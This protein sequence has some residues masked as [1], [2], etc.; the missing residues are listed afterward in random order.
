MNDFEAGFGIPQNAKEHEKE[1]KEETRKGINRLKDA[2]LGKADHEDKHA[3]E[4]EKAKK[5]NVMKLEFEGLAVKGGEEEF[6]GRLSNIKTWDMWKSKYGF[7]AS[8]IMSLKEGHNEFDQVTGGICRLADSGRLCIEL[9][10]NSGLHE[11]TSDKAV[12]HE[13]EPHGTKPEPD[14]FRKNELVVG[15]YGE[16][17]F[18]KTNL[19]F[20]IQG[21]RL[22]LDLKALREFGFKIGKQDVDLVAGPRYRKDFG[23]GGELG[24]EW[25]KVGTS[26]VVSQRATGATFTVRF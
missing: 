1:T 13:K 17:E 24:I 16:K 7:D 19:S 2:I 3:P 14:F 6:S 5:P 20:R 26:I 21:P 15:A 25:K 4:G 9:G 10:M 23:A 18:G 12:G 22:F 11:K 8:G